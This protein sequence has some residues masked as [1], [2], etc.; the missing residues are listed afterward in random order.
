MSG[1]RPFS[2]WRTLDP[3]LSVEEPRVAPRPALVVDW[4]LIRVPGAKP[5]APGRSD[6]LSE[7]EP[8]TPPCILSP[9][10]DPDA[11]CGERA[12]AERWSPARP[13]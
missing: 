1:P 8:A 10:A 12:K 5:D 3:G 2:Q 7:P 9:G 13:K 4:S 6:E 11:P